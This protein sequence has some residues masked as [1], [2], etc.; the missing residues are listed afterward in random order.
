ML[1]RVADPRHRRAVRHRLA[2]ILGLA[3]CA[4][5]A[6]ARSFTALA[7]W[8][9]DADAETLARLG[10]AGSV[11]SGSTFRRTLQ[12]LD[13]GVFDD[14][15]GRWAQRRTAPG[16]GSRRITILRL[17]GAPSTAA[18]LLPRKAACPATLDHPE[19]ANRLC[20][21]P[22]LGPPHS[23]VALISAVARP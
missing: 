23:A 17:S 19:G 15:A 20:R 16:P 13:A 7:E 3:V 11:P 22:P 10:A 4:V 21:S 1:G 12:R 14:L 6:G 5:L 2:V 8:A 18:A 9:A